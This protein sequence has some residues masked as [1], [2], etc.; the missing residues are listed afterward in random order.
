[1]L[2]YFLIESISKLWR[3]S[4]LGMKGPARAR[5]RYTNGSILFIKSIEL[6]GSREILW[7]LHLLMN[8]KT[9][10]LPGLK[11]CNI[12]SN[13]I[14]PG[15]SFHECRSY[16]HSPIYLQNMS[17]CAGAMIWRMS[18]ISSKSLPVIRER[19]W[20]GGNQISGCIHR[21]YPMIPFTKMAT[22]MLVSRNLGDRLCVK[23]N[24]ANI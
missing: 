17:G 22:V 4:V 18:L 16:R 24:L 10:I 19:L 9:R 13:N 23:Y 3:W 2:C 14:H 8:T 7:V 20:A 6:N 21:I 5:E 1:M 12:Q 15:S 11:I